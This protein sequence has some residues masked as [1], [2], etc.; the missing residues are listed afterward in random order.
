MYQGHMEIMV[1]AAVTGVTAAA[2]WW[3][4]RRR[5]KRRNAGGACGSCGDAWGADRTLER[6][7]IHGRLVCEACATRA[8]RRLP[9]HFAVLG[10]AGA[11]ATTATALSGGMTAFA[12]VPLVTA[13][14]LPVWAVK[15][16]KQA[17]RKALQK[18]RADLL[19]NGPAA[20]H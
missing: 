2:G 17:N 10:V 19:L 14:A 3:A 16:M 7:W 11:F 12:L 1:I 20:Q 4:D 5:A 9:V 6:Y 15:G 8:K 18:D 13:V